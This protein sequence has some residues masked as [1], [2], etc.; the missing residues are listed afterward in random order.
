MPSSKRKSQSQ[1]TG[2]LHDFFNAAGGPSSIVS[3]KKQKAVAKPKTP[4]N[5]DDV[6]IIHDSDSEPEVIQVISTKKRRRISDSTG[7]IEFVEQKLAVSVHG[8]SACTSS[9][10]HQNPNTSQKALEQKSSPPL[11]V[12]NPSHSN[13]A[14]LA[15]ALES[16]EAET[17]PFGPP[18]LLLN[19]PTGSAVTSAH[20][21]L[22]DVF[23]F[24]KPTLLLGS[25]TASSSSNL[26]A[27]AS[28]SLRTASTEDLLCPTPDEVDDMMDIPF[29][30]G[31]EWGTGDDETAFTR[32]DEEEE[33]QAEEKFAAS[34]ADGST[35]CLNGEE[36][37]VQEKLVPP[38]E[39]EDITRCPACRTLL[40]GFS[41]FE[42]TRHVNDCLDSEGNL[43][44]GSTSHTG[45]SSSELINRPKLQPL[46]SLA[47]P[48]FNEVTT[49]SSCN[50]DAKA[51]FSSGNAFSVLM[52]S[53]D[54]REA[55]KEADSAED[56]NFRP[57]KSNG[58]RR[59]APFYKV[60]QGMPIAVDA[61]RY[62]TIPGVN[63]YFL[64]H[65]H[66]D[67]Y[68]NLAANWKSGPIYCSEGTAK[69]IIH[70]L[71]VDPKWVHPLPY[72]VP[73]EI[74]NT[75][76]VSVTLIEANHCPGSCLFFYEGR[77]TVNA[78][79]SNHKSPF[80]GSM[81]VFRYLHCG[82]FRASPRH[83]LH[84]AVK[85]KRIDR[86]YLDTTYLNPKP[87]VISACAELAR[88]L[89]ACEPTGHTSTA[90]DKWVASSSISEKEKAP[91]T[92]KF[93]IVVGTYSIGKERI[94]KAIAHALSSKVYCDARKAAILRCQGDAE[95]DA[96]LTSNPLEAAVHVVPL[97]LITSDK[98]K[99]YLERFKGKFSKAAGFRPTGWT[100]TQPAGADQLPTIAS[101]ISRP[102]RDFDYASLRPA[103]NSVSN[104]QLFS[105]PYSEHSSFFELT[106]FAMSFNW[107][108]MIAT[109][110][111]GSENSRSKMNQWV[112]RWKAER[113]KRG[114]DEVISYRHNEYW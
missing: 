106:C 15:W 13:S 40:E 29:N 90:M 84:P 39:D 98:L 27:P 89:V 14:S 51:T 7:E 100:Y 50:G 101:I 11:T 107:G 59:K 62:G 18:I 46:T 6:I 26:D 33:A 9:R 82:D 91:K 41:E 114:K 25:D 81:K 36:E 83:V 10:D 44:Q 95:L 103:R 94:V 108:E 72:D 70:M 63:A 38:P 8:Q 66:S 77:Q 4:V 32:V 60:L 52:S 99:E 22:P 104:L 74:P 19:T 61:F 67:H 54:E 31:D 113:K 76:G 49:S 96:L 48:N 28:R 55:W 73:T 21:P 87:L 3:K 80:V 17:L 93:L 86:V 97:G 24:G 20:T 75:D 34:L 47:P 88:R 43:A 5:S 42:L 78:G 2:T 110:N 79:D 71:S 69:L 56:R 111:V 102:H 30:I 53:H 85:G 37:E 65:A 68:T 57:N 64:T 45:S 105:V 35:A 1:S 16:K 23:S 112:A 12:S 58:G 109:V 92:E